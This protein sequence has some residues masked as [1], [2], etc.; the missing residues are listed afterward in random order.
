VRGLCGFF[1]I[2]ALPVAFFLTACAGTQPSVNDPLRPFDQQT[3]SGAIIAEQGTP[4]ERARIHT[5]LAA[6]YYERGN[7]AV[8]LEELRIAISADPG[9]ASAYN[10][11]GLVHADLREYDQAQASFERALKISPTD[12]DTNHNYAWFL[13]QTD[14][15]EQSL[16]YFLAAVRNPLYATPQKSYFL[17]ATC[18]ARKNKNQESQDYFERA[19]KLDPNY[20][21][22]ILGLAQLKYRRGDLSDSRSLIVRYNRLVEPTAESLWLALRI[23]R[24]LGDKSAESSFAQQLRRQFSGTPE[25]QQLVKGQFD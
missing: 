12:A 19:I 22:A 17:A 24:K 8:S 7:L 23:E 9:Y 5:D 6:A 18:A 4:R 21:S 15:E 3:D 14:R 25:F 16:R 11:L 10:V 1:Q 13:C 20:A 2:L